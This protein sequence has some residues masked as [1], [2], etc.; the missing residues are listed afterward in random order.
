L[1]P[2]V[3][4]PHMTPAGAQNW[5]AIGLIWQVE[6]P[7]QAPAAG[8]VLEHAAKGWPW[9]LHEKQLVPAAHGCPQAV[10]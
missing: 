1:A 3:Q 6:L 7:A 10:S 4:V 9:S 8:H 2:I 5:S